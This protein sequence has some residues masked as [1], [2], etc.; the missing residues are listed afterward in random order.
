MMPEAAAWTM[1]AIV[2]AVGGWGLKY[3]I[4]IAGL[5][6]RIG[7]QLNDH[8]RRIEHVEDRQRSGPW[9]LQ[10]RQRGY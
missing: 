8:E 4:R 9:P 7:E 3:L 5:L 1:V 6:G 10:P 2:T